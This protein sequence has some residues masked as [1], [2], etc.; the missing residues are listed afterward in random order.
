ML[1]QFPGKKGG[2]KEGDDIVFVDNDGREYKVSGLKERD[3]AFSQIIGYSGIRW[4]RT[5]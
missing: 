2:G 3:L 4:Q 1:F 5:G